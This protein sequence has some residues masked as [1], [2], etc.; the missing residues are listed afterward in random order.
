MLDFAQGA[1]WLAAVPVLL[2]TVYLLVLAL[3]S[4]RPRAPAPVAPRLRFAVVVPA[5]DEEAGVA[6]TVRSLLAVVYPPE[7]F[8]VTVVADNC[9]D[10][11][12]ERA[13]EAGALVLVRHDEERR[14]K[15]FAL[16][17]AF[18][19]ILASGSVDAVAVV[20]ADTLVSPNLLLAFAARLEAGAPAVQ[21][22]YG[23]RNPDRSWRTRLM[24]IAFAL[25]NDVRSLGRQRL[26][27]SVGLRGN[28]MCFAVRVL[29]DVPHAAFSIV[30]D[31]EYGVRLG[32][33]GHRVHYV[34]EAEVLGDMPA[35]G[36]AAEV[37]RTR[38]ES[39]RR[40]M[41]REHAL[42]LLRAGLSSRNPILL[43][44][45]LD[46]AVPPL[47]Y[48]ALAAVLGLCVSLGLALGGGWPAVVP[49]AA[50]LS[51]MGVYVARGWWLSATGARGL[52]ALA[53]AP[54]Y[55]LWKLCLL[56][57]RPRARDGWVRTPREQ[58][59]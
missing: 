11:T 43:D 42:P 20:D 17:F 57:L 47:A 33:A 2:A 54:G 52:L 53:R 38:W 25:F 13:R 5:H 7:L 21:A 9:S 49:W 59:S 40:R 15:G 10:A 48:L 46:L 56:L 32:L 4:S 39:G 58:R 6:E 1:S 41:A 35:G 37:Q 22:R 24:S 51:A 34:H 14:G 55:L 18:D 12:A 31:L 16:T 8:R 23:V 36:E 27:C 50:S 19:R 28:G 45:G 29:R 3:A 30:E 26:G 44:L